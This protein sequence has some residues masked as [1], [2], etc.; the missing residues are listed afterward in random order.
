MRDYWDERARRN[1]AWYVDT[2]IDYADPDMEQFFA[3]GRTIV[4]E[5]LDGAPA[6]PAGRGLAVEIGSGLGRVCRALADRFDRVVGLDV[7]PEM[8]A[9]ARALVP[10]ERITFEVNDGTTVP[11]PDAS[12]DVVLSF[13]VFQ[14]I[15]QVALIRG[16]LREAGR[17]LR[18]GG[19]LVFQWNN[20]P[21][22][23]R[24]RM[25]RAVLATLQRTGIRREK[26]DRNAAEFLGSRVRLSTIEDALAHGS[27]DLRGTK[28]TGTLFAWAWAVKR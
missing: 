21:G 15:P 3:T 9:R 23:A 6:A 7:A 8:V 27:L 12:A 1:A 18:P 19:L 4:A 11:L 25:R 22:P 2:S 28:G 5:A 24:W 10:D 17:V 20:L 13:T 16:Y 26:H 14:H